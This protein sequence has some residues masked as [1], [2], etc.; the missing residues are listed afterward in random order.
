MTFASYLLFLFVWFVYFVVYQSGFRLKTTQH[1]GETP[2]LPGSLHADAVEI[3]NAIRCG[4]VSITGRAGLAN[5]VALN[6]G[7]GR[8]RQISG[9]LEV[10]NPVAHAL[11]AYRDAD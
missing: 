6:G 4:N 7:K 11:P 9:A 3:G 10:I 8:L 5:Y 2:A 1:A